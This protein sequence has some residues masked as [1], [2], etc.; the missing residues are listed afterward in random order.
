MPSFIQG[1][2]IPLGTDNRLQ[3]QVNKEGLKYDQNVTFFS[4]LFIWYMYMTIATAR[5]SIPLF[6]Y[7]KLLPY[8][9]FISTTRM[10]HPGGN[11]TTQIKL[12]QRTI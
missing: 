10:W 7:S 1:F 12:K 6:T 5:V 9:V 2:L 11:K 8:F 4:G 3:V